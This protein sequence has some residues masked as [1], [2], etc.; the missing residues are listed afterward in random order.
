MFGKP[1]KGVRKELEKEGVR[2]SAVVVDIA[3]RGI[4]IQTDGNVAG[5]EASLKTTLRVQPPDGMPAFDVHQAFRYS[6]FAVPNAG[7]HV[8]V[9]YDPDDHEHIMIDTS[10]PVSSV[11]NIVIDNGVVVQG[12]TGG[13]DVNAL[14]ANLASAVPGLD[15]TGTTATA[16]P[17]P[18][19]LDQ[20]AKL[21]ALK[22]QGLLTDAEFEEQ[23]ARILHPH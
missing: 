16:A 10:S 18:D 7:D 20:L 23:K 3:H 22:Q 4:S 21:G 5:A 17:A 11:R 9:I 1:R 6:Q 19:P 13:L 2:A 15:L 14:L 12:D 8:R